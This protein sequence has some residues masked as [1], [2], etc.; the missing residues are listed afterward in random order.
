MDSPARIAQHNRN[1]SAE[2]KMQTGGT[3]VEN[4]ITRVV[5]VNGFVRVCISEMANG[6]EP[7]D[8]LGLF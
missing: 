8:I 4:T 5:H 6:S 1:D 3:E 2:A 7:G